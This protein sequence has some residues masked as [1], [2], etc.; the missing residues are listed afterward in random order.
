VGNSWSPRPCTPPSTVDK[1]AVDR[2][3]YVPVI[4]GL[5]VTTARKPPGGSRIIE[6]N[7]QHPIHTVFFAEDGKQAFSGGAEG[8]LR[9]W[10]ADDGHEVGE[11]VRAQ[12]AEIHAAALSPDRK[13]LL[14][15]LKIVNQSGGK[16]NV[17]V[18][19][20]Q[21]HEKV[22]DID[23]HVLAVLSV[24][25]SRD[26]TKFATAAAGGAVFI[27]SMTTG[28]RL[29][30]PLIHDGRVVAVRFSP[31]GDRVAT[32][33]AE[34]PDAKSIRIYNS[35]NGQELLEIPFSVKQMISSSLAW[36]GDGRQLFAVSY[37][38]VKCF[39]TSSGILLGKWSTHN[40]GHPAC[41]ALARSQ[42]FIVVS[43][44][45]S[46]SF[47]DASTHK[48]IGNVINHGS[49]IRSAALSPDDD[50]IVTG[51]ENGK[52]TIRSLRDIL[53]FS[54]LTVNVSH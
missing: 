19:D 20:A 6:I 5:P 9:R 17:R 15:G 49:T 14:C 31:N 32:A 1:Y 4:G 37:G 52:V 13:W 33:T 50:R 47:W 41:I 23:D 29:A 38:G 36:S 8:M 35:D 40:G 34:N 42:K 3:R 48:Q 24:D 27:W 43:T 12:G 30:G 54:Y 11:P 51:E 53:P 22:R 21:T 26:S 7:T 45:N 46:L 10:R 18:W 39:D 16:A 25:I 2:R 44:N 28:K